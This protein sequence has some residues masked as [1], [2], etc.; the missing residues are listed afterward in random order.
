[1]RGDVNQLLTFWAFPFLAGVNLGDSNR[2]AATA[3]MEFYHG[4]LVGYDSNAFALGAVNLPAGEFV[5]N[6]DFL[7]A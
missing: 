2:L 7:A 3:A 1:M 4:R 6:V 5:A